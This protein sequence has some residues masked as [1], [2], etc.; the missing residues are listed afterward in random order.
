MGRV[1]ALIRELNAEENLPRMAYRR[2]ALIYQLVCI[3][4]KSKR[5]FGVG[6]CTLPQNTLLM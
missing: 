6:P 3:V 1:E 2:N 5:N 4:K